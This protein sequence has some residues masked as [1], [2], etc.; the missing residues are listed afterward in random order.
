M[1]AQNCWA[2]FDIEGIV[3]ST[4][5]SHSGYHGYCCA[6]KAWATREHM[7][8][9][10]HSKGIL[11]WRDPAWLTEYD[12]LYGSVSY[13]TWAQ[14]RHELLH[15]CDTDAR[16][17]MFAQACQANDADNAAWPAWGQLPMP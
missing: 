17:D 8:P 2:K 7:V 6:C 3:M 11:S 9:Q 13:L 1:A 12:K 10:K 16:R 14:A 15:H 4:N 5:P